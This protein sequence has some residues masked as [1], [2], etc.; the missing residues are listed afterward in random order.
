MK[1][2]ASII[3][4][5]FNEEKGL[6]AT[7]D[8]IKSVMD[9]AGSDYEIIV[10]D[11][12]STDGTK[13]VAEGLEGIRLITN[14]YNMGYGASLKR[15]I[16]VAQYDVIVITDAD[17]TYPNERIPDLVEKLVEGTH[18]VVGWRKG[19]N[20]PQPFH[21]KLAKWIIKTFASILV[22]DP[23]PDLNSGLR[24]FPK[25]LAVRHERILPSGFS[26][27]TT[28]T[29]LII[30]N[31]GHIVYEPIDY[32]PRQGSSKFHP[33][34]D[35]IAMVGLIVRSTLLFNPLRIFVPIAAVFI[36]ASAL[37]LIL[38]LIGVFERIPDATIVVL[39]VT[40]VQILFI[41][42][43]ADLINRRSS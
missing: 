40:G 31:G 18:M 8:H 13:E 34:K 3:V 5:A 23:I 29:L 22:R 2:P 10:V 36:S 7:V 15:G 42:L 9:E 16:Q 27:T 39:L 20:A 19:K 4:P 1:S 33:I 30:S 37:I 24:C 41:G 28:I 38:A 14:S 17:G 32:R 35:V 11:D 43:L 21:R 25:Y 26:F 6:A 12:G